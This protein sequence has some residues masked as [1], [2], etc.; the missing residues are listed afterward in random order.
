MNSDKFDTH[1]MIKTIK[2]QIKKKVRVSLCN[3]I[4]LIQ[5]NAWKLVKCQNRRFSLCYRQIWA[6]NPVYIHFDAFKASFLTDFTNQPYHGNNITKDLG[7][8]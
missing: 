7:T 8:I 1:L 2:N 3:S 4:C 5:I 6:A